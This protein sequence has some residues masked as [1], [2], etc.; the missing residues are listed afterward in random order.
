MAQKASKLRENLLLIYGH[1]TRKDF[2]TRRA[3]SNWID[4]ESFDKLIK[5]ILK[6]SNFQAVI[7]WKVM[8][9]PQN[10]ENN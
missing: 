6:P 3:E 5:A 1:L 10:L 7:Y 8:K 9:S 4:G 2:T